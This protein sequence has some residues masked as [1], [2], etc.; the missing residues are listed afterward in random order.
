MRIWN[1]VIKPA[2]ARDTQV[3]GSLR[4]EEGA[5]CRSLQEELG[6]DIGRG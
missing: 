3:S 1:E 6:T 4:V 2:L 5:H